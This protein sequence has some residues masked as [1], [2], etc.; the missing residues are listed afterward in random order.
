MSEAQQEGEFQRDLAMCGEGE[1]KALLAMRERA[2]TAAE[3]LAALR[4]ALRAK[5]AE[6]RERRS[7]TT[8][9]LVSRQIAD[10]IEALLVK[11]EP[12]P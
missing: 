7:E 3:E 12:K 5:V 11:E 1:R 9:P 2:M 10:E 4:E 8:P 6:L